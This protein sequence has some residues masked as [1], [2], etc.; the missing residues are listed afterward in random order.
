LRFARWQT[1]VDG[2]RR[3]ANG[4]RGLFVVALV[5]ALAAA[6]A[7][8]LIA[9]ARPAGG[10][11]AFPEGFSSTPVADGLTAPTAMAFAPDGSIFVTEQGGRLRVIDEGGALREE[12]FATLNVDSRKERGL[13]GVALDPAFASNGYVYVYH[14]TATDPRRNRIVRFTAADPQN[15]ATAS[16]DSQRTIFD[17]DRLGPKQSHNGGAIHFG[18]DGKLYVA[19]GD[20]GSRFSKEN[21]Q[22]LDTVFG[23]M[24]RLNKD[25]SIPKDNPFYDRARGNNRAIWAR[26]LRNPFSFAVQPGTGTILINDVGLH[27]W[28]EINRGARG[29]NF[30]W[31]RYEGPESNGRF[32]PPI[33]AYRHSGPQGQTGCA[34]TGGTFYNPAV[35]TYPED[36]VGDYFFADFCNGWVRRYDPAED[37]AYPFASGLFRTVDL[38]VGPDGSLY[39]L[40]REGGSVNRVDYAPAGGAPAQAG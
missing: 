5:A 24:L 33:F 25:G 12:P 37:R 38:Q 30:G 28:E 20:N 35:P 21:P 19:V 34:I 13:L 6:A 2:P 3:H 14:T 26:G 7:V 11:M 8:V 27:V 1:G 18:E 29:A 32:R 15:P 39:Y 22:T 23:K 9:P 17:L 36:F 31:P 40:E 10:A 4:A 16:A